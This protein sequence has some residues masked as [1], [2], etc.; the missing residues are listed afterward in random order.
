MQATCDV[1]DCPYCDGAELAEYDTVRRRWVCPRCCREWTAV[2]APVVRETLCG[3]LAPRD[4]W[5]RC[6]GE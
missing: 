4:R 2:D 5:M 1:R 6:Y 3:G